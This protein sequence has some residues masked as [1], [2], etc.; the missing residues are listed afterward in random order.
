MQRNFSGLIDIADKIYS[1]NYFLPKDLNINGYHGGGFNLFAFRS[2][3]W[4]DYV[5]GSLAEAAR[6][7][8]WTIISSHWLGRIAFCARWAA[9]K[10]HPV[11]AEATGKAEAVEEVIPSARWGIALERD[12]TSEILTADWPRRT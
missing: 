1:A 7:K 5:S 6:F 12:F 8:S 9:E 2:E 3:F 10:V 4:R 11:E